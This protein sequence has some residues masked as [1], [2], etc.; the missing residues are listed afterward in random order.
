MAFS[1]TGKAF[2]SQRNLDSWLVKSAHNHYLNNVIGESLIED[3]RN[4]WSNVKTSKS[5][6]NGGNSPLLKS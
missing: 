1:S 5:E 3:L 4:F 2:K 6:N